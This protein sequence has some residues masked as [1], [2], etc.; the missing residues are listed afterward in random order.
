MTI[1]K[2]IETFSIAFFSVLCQLVGQR[3]HGGFLA[4]V[5]MGSRRIQ[6]EK[7]GK[8]KHRNRRVA[9]SPPYA[10]SSPNNTPPMSMETLGL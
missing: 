1:L 5:Q 7:R 9:K 3:F 2:K 8:V 4:L 6:Q 10:S